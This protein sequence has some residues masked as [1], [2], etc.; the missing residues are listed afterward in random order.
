MTEGLVH[1]PPPSIEVISNII[2]GVEIDEGISIVGEELF[3]R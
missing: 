2:W 1:I 3:I